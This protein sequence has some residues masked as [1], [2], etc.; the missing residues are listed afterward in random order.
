[1]VVVLV[2]LEIFV[3]L[4]KVLLLDNNG[5]IV[6][7]DMHSMHHYTGFCHPHFTWVLAL[8]TQ[9]FGFLYCGNELVHRAQTLVVLGN[10]FP[11]ILVYKAPFCKGMRFQFILHLVLQNLS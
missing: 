4:E 2:V 6:V 1:L 3:E 5:N 7:I 11:S 9:V 10:K 8:C